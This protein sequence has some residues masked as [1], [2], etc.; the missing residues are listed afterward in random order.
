MNVL[1][2]LG[3]DN[4]GLFMGSVSG[5]ERKKE[6]AKYTHRFSLLGFILIETS[7]GGLRVQN[8]S[9][10]SLVA[11]V[12]EKQDTDYNTPEIYLN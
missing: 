2:D 10:S 8:G 4:V 7:D 12:K 1:Y 9:K 11:E 5:W 3:K 6:L